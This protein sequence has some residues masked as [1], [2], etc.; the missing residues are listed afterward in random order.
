MHDTSLIAGS[1]FAD[2]YGAKEK[3]VIDIGGMDVYNCGATL[4]RFFEDKG[5]KYISIDLES[6][7]SVDIVVK[8]SEKLPFEDGSVDLI[9]STSCF[10]HDP[11]FWLTFKE[12]SRIVKLGGYIYVNAPSN[13]NYHGFP[14]DNWRFYSDAG[15]ALAYWSGIKMGNEKIYP[16]SVEETFHILPLNDIWCDFVCIWKRVN[17]TESS[18]IVH[19][20][21]IKN[22]GLLENSLTNKGLKIIKK[23]Y[24]TI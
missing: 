24:R 2:L 3:I 11:C 5:M 14:G 12:M 23:M 15:Q 22:T 18:I 6:H 1:T 13:G 4:R 20:D 21:K 7:P 16:C 19:E 9:V 17:T 8:P 10:E